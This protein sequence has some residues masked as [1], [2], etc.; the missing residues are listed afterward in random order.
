MGLPSR[1][2]FGALASR[3]PLFA[4]PARISGVRD[5]ASGDSLRSVHWKASAREQTLQVK[6]FQPAIA[7]NV[8]L[9]LDLKREAYP[10]RSAIGSSEWAISVA[11]S[12]ASYVTDE[13]QPVGLLCNGFDP[14]SEAF[15]MRLPPHTGRGHLMQ[16]LEY[17]ARVQMRDFTADADLS[18]ATWLP[19]QLTHL[20]WGTTLILVT[21]L[22]DEATLW[23]LHQAR[24]RGS[25]VIVLI[26]APMRDL[27]AVQSRAA[28][29]GVSVYAT[30]W[31]RDFQ[32]V[33]ESG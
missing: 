21:P 30:Q 5:Y 31:E 4:D 10:L 15:G 6:K 13:R 16:I 26:C 33:A 32:R 22:L 19:T 7:L 14:L 3:Q 23:S 20:D 11:A 2:P 25:S 12:L 18:L 8:A 1:M 24:R 17:L 27:A 29:L 28:A 9:V